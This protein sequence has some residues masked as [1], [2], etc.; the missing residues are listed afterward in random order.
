MCS[1]VSIHLSE[2]NS[3]SEE[4]TVVQTTSQSV[5]K[6]SKFRRYLLIAVL[7][8]SPLALSACGSGNGHSGNTTTTNAP[9]Y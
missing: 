8:A 6:V 5:L 9:G 1:I 7:V 2:S 3:L 4:S